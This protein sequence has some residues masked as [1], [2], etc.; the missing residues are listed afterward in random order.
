MCSSSRVHLVLSVCVCLC[1]E[2]DS[3]RSEDAIESVS[4]DEDE[5]VGDAGEWA[6]IN[7]C[8]NTIVARCTGWHAAL[9]T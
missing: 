9:I 4:D 5:L 8:V 2:N 3:K 7:R 1:A 6:G